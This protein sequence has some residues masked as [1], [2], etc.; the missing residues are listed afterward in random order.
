[1]NAKA[2]RPSE[3]LEDV[4]GEAAFLRSGG[5]RNEF[6]FSCG[7]CHHWLRAG[8]GRNQRAAIVAAASSC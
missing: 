8:P 5:H 3:F 7:E 6:T 4:H 2:R 1:M